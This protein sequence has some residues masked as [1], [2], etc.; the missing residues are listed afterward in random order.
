[1]IFSWLRKRRRDRIL[2]QP[3]P[4]KWLEYLDRN[5]PHYRLLTT[6]EQARLRDNLLVFIAEKNWE[7]C[8]GLEL[9]DE[10]KV[11]I[12]GEACLMALGLEG[13]PFGRVESILVY[14]SAYLVPEERWHEGWSI[15][16]QQQREGE[17]HYRGPVILSWADV[18]R[19]SRRTGRGRNLVWHEFAHQLDMLDRSVNG[20]PPLADPKERRRWHDV[21]TAEYEQLIADA[22][23]GHA[24]LLDTYGATNETEFF[25]VASECFFDC[26]VELRA[27]HTAL[28]ELLRDYYGQDPAERMQRAP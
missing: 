8:A 11:T 26:P 10:M 15:V 2:A 1:M 14:P 21:M 20:T 28:Y 22:Q 17:A 13:E 3:F 24:T 27:E 7:G 16:G 4:P 9:T 19:D 18:R 25:A 23:E 12:A 6:E 5:V